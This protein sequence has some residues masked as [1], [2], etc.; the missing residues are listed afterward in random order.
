MRVSAGRSEVRAGVV[1]QPIDGCAVIRLDVFSDPDDGF[2]S[3]DP[4]T[5]S[6]DLTKVLV[7]GPTKL[8]LDQHS[9]VRLVLD[10]CK[11]IGAERAAPVLDCKA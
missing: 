9:M 2:G 1:V 10:A 4:G 8:V 3:F 5:V 11:N 7:V 6:H